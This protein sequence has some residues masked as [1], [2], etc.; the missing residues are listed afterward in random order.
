M[1]IGSL[2]SKPDTINKSVTF[3]LVFCLF[4]LLCEQ[5]TL[6]GNI[7]LYCSSMV[8]GFQIIFYHI[9]H[10]WLVSFKNSHT[11]F[12]V[13]KSLIWHIKNLSKL[14]FIKSELCFLGAVE[15]WITFWRI[16]LYILREGEREREECY[17]PVNRVKLT[18]GF[19]SYYTNLW[20]HLNIHLCFPYPIWLVVRNLK[21]IQ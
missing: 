21:W 1:S 7:S 19:K 20:L 6:R 8:K 9:E 2:L 4:A 14:L 18:V 5:K 15:L 13:L 12:L 17:S 3:P 16:R 10:T 11:Y